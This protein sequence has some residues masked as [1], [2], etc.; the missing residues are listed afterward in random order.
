MHHKPL[1]KTQIK[2]LN[3]NL[4][5]FANQKEIVLL[6]QDIDDPVNVGSI[7]RTADAFNVSHIY[8]SDKSAKVSNPKVSMTSRGLER[9]LEYSYLKDISAKIKDLKL[10]GFCIIS[11]ELS[12]ESITYKDINYPEKICLILGSEAHGIY[13]KILS[14][15]DIIVAI[16]MLGKGPSLNVSVAGAIILSE[17]RF[18]KNG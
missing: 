18:N 14:E 11:A 17:I 3:E 10:S 16:P 2:R 4:I 1:S 6:L 13:K 9:K 7:F 5:K 8:L 12:E 15:S